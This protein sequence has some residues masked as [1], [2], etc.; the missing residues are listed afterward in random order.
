MVS[1]PRM[2]IRP[3]VLPTTESMGVGDEAERL[4]LKRLIELLGPVPR[5]RTEI[6]VGVQ[7]TSKYCRSSMKTSEHECHNIAEH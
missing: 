1:R 7:I 2:K 3:A 4:V 6:F 5:P